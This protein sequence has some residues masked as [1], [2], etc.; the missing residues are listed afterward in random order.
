MDKV[1]LTARIRA[2]FHVCPFCGSENFTQID[3]DSVDLDA[4]KKYQCHGCGKEWTEK[5]CFVEAYVEEEVP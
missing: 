2:N 1:E 3:V 5:Y 4:F